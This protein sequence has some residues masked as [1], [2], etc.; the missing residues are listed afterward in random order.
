MS[1]LHAIESQYT[2]IV[3]S[4]PECDNCKR[5]I[6]E[7][8]ADPVLQNEKLR[9]LMVYPDENTSAW[10]LQNR[11]VP[12]GWIDAYSPDGEIIGS[13]LY[14]IP[15]MPSLYLLDSEK[16]VVLKDA[17]PNVVRSMLKREL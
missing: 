10:K 16:R 7:L 15:A 2:L 3:F 11:N 8:M 13:V 14:Y 12:E 6:P 17:H 5:I 9:V 4:D 1:A